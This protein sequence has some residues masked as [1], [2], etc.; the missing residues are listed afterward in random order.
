MGF[1]V[2]L[3]LYIRWALKSGSII[4]MLPPFINSW[5]DFIPELFTFLRMIPIFDF[6][7]WEQ[8]PKYNLHWAMRSFRVRVAGFGVLEFPQGFFQAEGWD[9]GGVWGL[10]FGA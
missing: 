8:D 6:Y 1:E 10:G 7:G 2:C 4:R 5:I 3:G 9:I